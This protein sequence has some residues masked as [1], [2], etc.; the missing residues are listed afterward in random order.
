MF[1]VIFKKKFFDVLFE[2][3]DDK[4]I[5][6]YTSPETG[7]VFVHRSN[8]VFLKDLRKNISQKGI[9]IKDLFGSKKAFA[10]FLRKGLKM[11]ITKKEGRNAASFSWDTVI[12]KKQLD[13]SPDEA[14]VIY[15][16]GKTIQ[17][18]QDEETLRNYK[19]LLDDATDKKKKMSDQ[20]VKEKIKKIELTPDLKEK[21][22]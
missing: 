22:I 4:K 17:I 15:Q 12:L 11:N 20:S 8:K 13:L 5:R 10:T 16:S 9:S 19:L 3:F 2:N 14:L 18:V 7:K 1:S 21:E 6:Q